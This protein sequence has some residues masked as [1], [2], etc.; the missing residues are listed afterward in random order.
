MLFQRRQH[1][2]ERKQIRQGFEF[3]SLLW[4]STTITVTLSPPLLD[5]KNKIDESLFL[6]CGFT[7]HYHCNEIVLLSLSYLDVI[8]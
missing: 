2:I 7:F 6:L 1:E 4:F 5:I 8:S 3:R